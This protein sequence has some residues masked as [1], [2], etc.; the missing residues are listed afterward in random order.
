MVARLRANQKAVKKMC[1]ELK[2]KTPVFRMEFGL[3]EL[4]AVEG[5]LVLII[6][7]N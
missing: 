2:L 6:Q 7:M 3:T 4:A 1:D 5:T